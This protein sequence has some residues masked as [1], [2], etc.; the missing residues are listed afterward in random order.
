M[1]VLH[2]VDPELAT[3]ETARLLT[4]T[5]QDLGV[6]PNLARVMASSPAVLKGYL[7]TVRALGAEGT[8]PGGLAERIAL[9]VA[10]ESRSDYCLSMH[11]FRGTNVAGLPAAE[12]TRA[13]RGETGDPQAAAV[14]ALAAAVLRHHGAVS[15]DQLALVRHAGLADGQIVEIIAHVALG[16]FTSYLATAARCDIDWPLVRHTG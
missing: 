10:Q 4:A 8:L 6:V 13:R 14:L 15:A 12:V 9:L 7:G 16:V 2:N 5:H 1:Q 3:G 11:S